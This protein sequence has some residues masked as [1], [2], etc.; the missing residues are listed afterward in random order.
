M[1]SV[2][3][4]VIEYSF[5][6]KSVLLKLLT[7]LSRAHNL[8]SIK[9]ITKRPMFTNLTLAHRILQSYGSACGA[10][11]GTVSLFITLPLSCTFRKHSPSRSCRAKC[12]QEMIWYAIQFTSSA[13][14]VDIIHSLVLLCAAT[15]DLYFGHPNRSMS[16]FVRGVH[17]T[18]NQ[19]R[20]LI[21]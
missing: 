4:F 20:F 15:R 8:L 11:K 17:R 19:H 10:S 14:S 2:P 12:A 21:R 1:T 5:P 18:E 3:I 6:V 7:L 16:S 9:F 13:M